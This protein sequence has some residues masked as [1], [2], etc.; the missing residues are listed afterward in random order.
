MPNLNLFDNYFNWTMSYFSNSDIHL[1]YG[2]IEALDTAPRTE[3]E[4]LF[5][6]KSIR[7][8]GINPASGK[9]KLAIWLVS[10]CYA[11][12]NRLQY[13]RQLQ[14]FLDVDIISSKGKC[15]GK[16]LC[17]KE[18]NEELCYDMIEKTYKFYLS[19][20]N[21]ICKE[22]VTE[23]FFN[24]IARNVVPIVLG[25]ADYASIAP[26]HSYINA[27]DYTPHKLAEYLK[28]LDRNDSLYAEFFWW[29]PHYRVLNLHRSNQ[30]AFCKL[31]ADLHS[32]KAKET[33]II[34]GLQ[35]WYVTES[36]CNR[37]KF[38]QT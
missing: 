10:N 8:S 38:N 31:C 32:I 27:L 14:K 21:S 5:M 12:S 16:D 2:R 20:E 15:G 35:K 18:K 34:T 36:Q 9:S 19:F 28:L 13:V 29:K 4:R 24:A 26:N 23:K 37:P 22:Y 25:G 33:K 7:A 30:E 1:P 17:P 3:K 6:Q 11:R